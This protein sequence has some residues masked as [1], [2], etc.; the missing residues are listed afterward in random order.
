MYSWA[1]DRRAATRPPVRTRPRPRRVRCAQRTAGRAA[2]RSTPWRRGS[3]RGP[4]RRA[5]APSPAHRPRPTAPGSRRPG[6]RRAIAAGPSC[7]SPLVPRSRSSAPPRGVLARRNAAGHRARCRRPTNAVSRGAR[8]SGPGARHAK[9]RSPDRKI[10]GREVHLTSGAVGGPTP[11]TRRGAMSIVSGVGT[12][13]TVASSSVSASI[14]TCR[15]RLTSRS[16]LLACA[17]GAAALMLGAARVDAAT[18]TNAPAMH[19]R[20]ALD[21]P[22]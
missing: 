12:H 16:A 13:R 4:C 19:A 21:G 17:A 7:R 5:T 14:P 18:P 20:V 9:R 1:D 22:S 15:R 6:V 8:S 2:R 11:G 3:W 10:T